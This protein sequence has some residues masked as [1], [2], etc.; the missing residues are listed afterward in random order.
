MSCRILL[1]A[2]IFTGSNPVLSTIIHTQSIKDMENIKQTL[3]K[4]LGHIYNS[5]DWDFIVCAYMSYDDAYSD[6]IDINLVIGG[7]VKK[8]IDELDFEIDPYRTDLHGTIWYADG[9]WSKYCVD[10]DECE[11]S[12][13]RYVCPEIPEHLN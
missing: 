1:K 7:D 6:A 2:H 13:T 5:Q 10:Y 12:W 4:H 3:I 11:G 8:F 9:T